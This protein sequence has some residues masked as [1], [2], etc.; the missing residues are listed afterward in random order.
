MLWNSGTTLEIQALRDLKTGE[1]TGYIEV[2]D[3]KNT[4]TGDAKTSMSLT[5]LG[6]VLFLEVVDCYNWRS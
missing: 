5:R 6:L 2:L 1:V 4:E 3:D